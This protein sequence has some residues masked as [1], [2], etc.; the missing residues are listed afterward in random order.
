M[1][2][3]QLTSN[4]RSM[5][6]ALAASSHLDTDQ[7]GR[8]CSPK[9]NAQQAASTLLELRKHGLAYSMQKPTGTAYASW[10]ITSV[11]MAVFEG[12]PDSD[13]RV[14][15]VASPTADVQACAPSPAGKRYVLSVAGGVGSFMHGVRE[16]VLELAQRKATEQPGKEY[17][18]Y[19]QIAVAHMPVPQAQITLL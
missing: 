14:T 18:V 11:G 17:H 8:A 4:M 12:R 3:S 2:F 5:I 9:L 13:V 10:A 16:D 7:L 15:S 19:E 1:K 6:A